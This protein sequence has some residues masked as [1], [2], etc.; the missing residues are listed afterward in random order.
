MQRMCAIKP[1]F[2]GGSIPA[3]RFPQTKIRNR[4]VRSILLVK[5]FLPE[6]NFLMATPP[7]P[8]L[9]RAKIGL[10]IL[11]FINLF[12]YLDR[13]VVSALVESLRK[14]ELHLNDF[15]AGSLTTGF[16]IVYM[17]TS[18]IF[19]TLGDRRSRP[20]LIAT[21]VA[22][23]SF[24]TA[25]G[26]LAR[27]FGALFLARA[28]VGIGE[29]A[30]GTIAPSLLADYFPKNKRGRIFAIFFAAIPIGSALGYAVGGLVDQH[31]GWRAAFYV[32]GIPGIFLSLLVLGL[33][34]PPRGIHDPDDACPFP[35]QGKTIG[36]NGRFT[37]PYSESSLPIDGARLRR[38]Y[39][40][41]RRFGLLDAGLPGTG[42][43]RSKSGGDRSVWSDRGGDRV[44]RDLLRRLDR[45]LFPEILAAGL[46]LGFRYRHAPCCPS[47]AVSPGGKKP[48]GV[49]DG[50]HW[51]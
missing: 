24:A 47:G 5:R 49:F 37:W 9:R 3:N 7:T 20:R 43:R 1:C 21:G 44:H 16:L 13:W 28:A 38:L 36:E 45:R 15:E 29:A 35:T 23:W 42:A 11:T 34:D 46:S 6:R 39:L 17:L 26:G 8:S 4:N 51:G 10:L 12:N 19:G 22:I 18:P 31:F 40:C 33:P 30:Y 2:H 32:A 50:P 25:L 27:S 48:G 14:S 41:S